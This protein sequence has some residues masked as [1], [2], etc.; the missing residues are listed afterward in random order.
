MG[1]MTKDIDLALDCSTCV[2][3][4]TTACGDCVVHHLLANDAGPIEFV[5]APTSRRNE[6]VSETAR[7]VDLLAQAGL[8]DAEPQFVAY[9]EF[10]SAGVP[11][12]A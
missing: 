5:P 8:L 3:A 1:A 6:P 12:L 7:V 11:Q 10:E 4:N 9:S 2:A